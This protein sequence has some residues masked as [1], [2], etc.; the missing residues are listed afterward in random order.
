MQTFI[1]LTCL[2]Q[3]IFILHFLCLLLFPS[4][5]CFLFLL[6]LVVLLCLALLSFS[7]FFLLLLFVIFLFFCPNITFP[8][9]FLSAVFHRYYEH[10]YFYSSFPVLTLFHLNYAHSLSLALLFTPSL[11]FSSFLIISRHFPS[12]ILFLFP[13]FLLSLDI[14]PLSL[15]LSSFSFFYFFIPSLIL[16]CLRR[17]IFTPPTSSLDIFL[18]QYFSFTFSSLSTLF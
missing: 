2:L 16:P 18:P 12:L 6:F 4:L 3:S 5:L 14:P 9:S 8:S 11:F 7:L 17:P 1:R 10:S 15:I 13:L